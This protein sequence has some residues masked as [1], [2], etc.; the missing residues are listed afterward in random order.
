M[1]GVP[2]TSC[3]VRIMSMNDTGGSTLWEELEDGGLFIE[4]GD[5]EAE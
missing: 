4:L 2:N 1:S 5:L 3:V